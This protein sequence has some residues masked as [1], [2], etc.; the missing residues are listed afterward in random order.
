MEY[1]LDITMV[2]EKFRIHFCSPVPALSKEE[3]KQGTRARQTNI[4][5]DK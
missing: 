2:N 3:A 5:S 1:V 4:V